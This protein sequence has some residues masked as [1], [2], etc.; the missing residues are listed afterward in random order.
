M[1]HF[2]EIAFPDGCVSDGFVNSVPKV[3]SMF[4][5]H[6]VSEVLKNKDFDPRMNSI[7]EDDGAVEFFIKLK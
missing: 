6:Q 4:N 1:S 5:G 3:G 2:V 7:E